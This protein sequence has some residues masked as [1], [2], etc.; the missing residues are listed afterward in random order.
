MYTHAVIERSILK[1]PFEQVLIIII[2]IIIMVPIKQ[3]LMSGD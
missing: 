3:V 1:L 2:N